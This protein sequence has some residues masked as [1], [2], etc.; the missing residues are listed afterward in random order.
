MSITWKIFVGDKSEQSNAYMTE[1]RALEQA[2]R[3]ELLGR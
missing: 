3:A 2:V 1:A